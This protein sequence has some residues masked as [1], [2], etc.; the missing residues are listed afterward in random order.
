MEGP[1][2]LTCL[3]EEVAFADEDLIG[4]PGQ[5]L[6]LGAVA[7]A[8]DGTAGAARS[9]WKIFEAQDFGDGLDGLWSG[10]RTNPIVA[11][12]QR[13]AVA[14]LWLIVWPLS[15]PAAAV[16]LRALISAG[17]GGLLW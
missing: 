10:Y 5:L 3:S 13:S 11:A 9:E 16:A 15:S 12:T 8:N 14:S 1:E 6:A 2:L 4:V 17:M 7:P